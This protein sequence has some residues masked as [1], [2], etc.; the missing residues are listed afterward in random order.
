MGH[1]LLTL[2]FLRP[3][4]DDFLE[5]RLTAAAS[6]HGI[7]HAE[8]VFEDGNA[9]SIVMNGVAALRPRSLSNPLY[10]TVTLSVP[11]REYQA[12]L[13]F[14]REAHN[15]ALGFDATGMYLCAIHPGACLHRGSLELG[16][17][18]CSKIIS[19][20]LLHAGVAEAEGLVP[21]CTSPSALYAAV[22]GSGRRTCHSVRALPQPLRVGFGPA[23][24]TVNAMT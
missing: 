22:R 12:C 8:L 23:A 10:E 20:A 6:W 11:P 16:K 21:S 2:A 14:C 13:R 17:T 15:R 7:C 4:P 19:E 9:F 18:F 3:S 5:N 1:R 24:P